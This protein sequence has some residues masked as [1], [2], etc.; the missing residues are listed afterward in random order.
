MWLFDLTSLLTFISSFHTKSKF[1]SDLSLTFETV[2]SLQG[3]FI[4]LIVFFYRSK[5]N[6][7]P[8]MK[9]FSKLFARET[10]DNEGFSAAETIINNE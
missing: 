9:H 7:N 10:E 8:V 2:Y 4:Y 5:Q 1:T 3:L 6:E